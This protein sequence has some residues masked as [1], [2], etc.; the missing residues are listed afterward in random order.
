MKVTEAESGGSL[1]E[2]EVENDADDQK[3]DADEFRPGIPRLQFNLLWR[4]GI[5]QPFK[6]L[7]ALGAAGRKREHHSDHETD[8][9]GKTCE[10]EVLGHI[11]WQHGK[12]GEIGSLH[13]G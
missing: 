3:Y 11:T 6:L 1:P 4:E 2:D 5:D 10:P 12:L 7:V 9:E 13:P 8:G